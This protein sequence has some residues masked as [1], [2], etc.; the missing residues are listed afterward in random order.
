VTTRIVSESLPLSFLRLRLEDTIH[1]ILDIYLFLA[2]VFPASGCS[3]T[4]QKSSVIWFLS[5][6]VQLQFLLLHVA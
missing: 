1:L 3:D 6:C 4:S 2:P 5:H